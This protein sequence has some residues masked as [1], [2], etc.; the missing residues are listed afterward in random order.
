[1][2]TCVFGFCLNCMSVFCIQNVHLALDLYPNFV[3]SAEH[4]ISPT[5]ANCKV[6]IVKMQNMFG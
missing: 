1:M 5:I 2:S 3:I 6:L 4:D